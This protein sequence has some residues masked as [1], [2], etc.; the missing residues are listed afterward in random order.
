MIKLIGC[1]VLIFTVGK[2]VDWITFLY[3]GA[4]LDTIDRALLI[5]SII[6][7]LLFIMNG[8]I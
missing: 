5:F 4:I 8:G 2:I 3:T 1:A 6:F 7:V